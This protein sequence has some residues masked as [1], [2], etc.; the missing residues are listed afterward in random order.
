MANVAYKR[1]DIITHPM[2]GKAWLH[3][4]E[5]KISDIEVCL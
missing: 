3:I 1:G 2:S 4:A 5:V